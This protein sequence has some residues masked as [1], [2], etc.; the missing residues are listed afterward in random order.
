MGASCRA[1]VVDC[2]L[3]EPL[4][5]PSVEGVGLAPWV[6]A[7]GSEDARIFFVDDCG[8]STPAG[9][10]S[11]VVGEPSSSKKLSSKSSSS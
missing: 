8:L 4:P 1:G 6:S 3:P 10:L 2:A 5:D 7:G 9:S 11:D